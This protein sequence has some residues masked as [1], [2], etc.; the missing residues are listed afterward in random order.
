MDTEKSIPLISVLM[1]VYNEPVDYVIM[2]IESML[3]QTYKNLEYIF[4]IDDP[5]REDII[6]YLASKQRTKKIKIIRNKKNLG[7]T[8]SLNEGLPFCNGDY[9]A[10]MD[11]DDIACENRIQSELKYLIANKLDI[12]GCYV[13]KIDMENKCIGG[14]SK[15]PVFNYG[16]IEYLKSRS[17][18]I[19]PSWLVKK[20]VYQTL[21]GY[22]QFIFAEDYDFL[23]RASK[24]YRMACC[25]TVGLFYRINESGISQGNRLKQKMVSLFLRRH[26]SIIDNVEQEDLEEFLQ[27]CKAE[28]YTIQNYFEDIDRIRALKRE[29]DF[30]FVLLYLKIVFSSKYARSSLLEIIRIKCIMFVSNILEKHLTIER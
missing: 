6:E 28:E 30:R 3:N 20:K 12:V 14:V 24:K 2:A 21:D 5:K 23:L 8:S 16:C 29:G 26:K 1:C 7:L 13:Q 10:R 17:A 19:H 25:P 27:N 9:I 11:A 18:L 15:Y 4:V 22:R